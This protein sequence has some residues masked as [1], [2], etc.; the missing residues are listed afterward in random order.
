MPT[1]LAYAADERWAFVRDGGRIRLVRPP[2]TQDVAASEAEVER[3]VTVHGFVARERDFPTRRALLDFLDDESVRVW[4]ERAAPKPIDA[5][6]DD[7]L[8]ALTVTDLERQVDRARKKIDAGKHDQAQTLLSRLLAA[9]AITG[10]QRVAIATLLQDAQRARNE[11]EE[12][13]RKAL[14]ALAPA[15][16]A[17]ATRASS[18][19]RAG[20]EGPDILRP[21]A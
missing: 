9:A 12:Q 7:L 5:L 13:R 6:R 17:R 3:A 20:G 19:G 18:G 21:A 16:F 4:R 10:E 1:L 14:G 8:A 15:K 2:F 11:Q